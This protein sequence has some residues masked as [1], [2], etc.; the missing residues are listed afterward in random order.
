MEP[1]NIRISRWNEASRQGL[2]LGL[3]PAA[4]LYIG[5][6]QVAIGAAG[7][8]SSLIGIILWVAKFVGCIMIMKHV[9]KKFES[10][11]P[12]ATN[13]DIF[14][15]G[16][17][18]AMFSALFFSVITVADQVY[19]FPEYYQSVYAMT[20]QEYAK[21]WPADKVDEL[22][23]LLLDAPKISFIGT[24]IYCFIYGTILSF[25]LSRNIPSSDPFNNY[26]IDEQ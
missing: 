9:M 22:K 11:H 25:I 4:Y 12:S 21:V 17:L 15:L 18:M 10:A 26:K 2:L 16:V 19:I 14:K 3:I 5:H 20:L 24:F 1:N 23:E 6:I 13:S 7:F 8:F